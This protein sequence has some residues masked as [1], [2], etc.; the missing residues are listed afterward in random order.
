MSGNKGEG[1]LDMDGVKKVI[2]EL[3]KPL[4]ERSLDL[5]SADRQ[6]RTCIEIIAAVAPHEVI[7]Q[8]LEEIK[9]FLNI[10]VQRNTKEPQDS[11]VLETEMSKLSSALAETRSLRDPMGE[12]TAADQNYVAIVLLEQFVVLANSTHIQDFRS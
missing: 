1:L 8:Y 5:A 3:G 12:K 11:I 7:R 6:Q 2:G 9:S 4:D 10:A